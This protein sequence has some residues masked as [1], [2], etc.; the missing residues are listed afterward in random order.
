MKKSRFAHT[1]ITK[2]G[3]GNNYGTGVK[4]KLGRMRED[5]LGMIAVTPP[6]LKKPPKSL[7]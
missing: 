6:K 5:S 3:M 4:Q 7:A 2:K 1:P